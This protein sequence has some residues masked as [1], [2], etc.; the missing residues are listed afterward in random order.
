MLQPH[1]HQIY[2]QQIEVQLGVQEDS[3]P[4]ITGTTNQ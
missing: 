4:H 2:E 3:A 1:F